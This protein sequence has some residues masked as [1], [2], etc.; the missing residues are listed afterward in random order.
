MRNWNEVIAVFFGE[1][2]FTVRVMGMVPEGAGH[3][4]KRQCRRL[5]RVR[6]GMRRRVVCL[7]ECHR[8]L[9]SETIWRRF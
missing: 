4:C 1:D 5:K 3:A 9:Q 8:S 6:M 7:R 2:E